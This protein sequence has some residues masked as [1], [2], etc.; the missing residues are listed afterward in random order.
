MEPQALFVNWLKRYTEAF[1][2]SIT[3]LGKILKFSPNSLSGYLRKTRLPGYET[4][5]R[6]WVGLQKL[7]QAG[8]GPEFT[9]NVFFYERAADHF[10]EKC[11]DYAPIRESRLINVTQEMDF[12]KETEIVTRT[13]RCWLITFLPLAGISNRRFAATIK[14]EPG[15]I[16]NHLHGRNRPKFSTLIQV[17]KYLQQIA[18]K[19]DLE[20]TLPFDADIFFDSE[21]AKVYLTTFA[22]AIFPHHDKREIRRRFDHAFL[23]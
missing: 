20:D 5:A 12:E 6:F 11:Y 15:M 18:S 19:N 22:D 2:L 16:A 8:K 7:H 17:G 23:A 3:G 21:L 1:K 4:L 9:A 10:I 13:Y 14:Q